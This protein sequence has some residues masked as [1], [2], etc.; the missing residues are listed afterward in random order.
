MWKAGLEIMQQ[1]ILHYKRN[2]IE[3]LEYRKDGAWKLTE[4]LNSEKAELYTV[5][6]TLL[7]SFSVII[8]PLVLFLIDREHLIILRSKFY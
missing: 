7:I 8:S 5:L 6:Y 3:I 4:Q 1:P 2:R